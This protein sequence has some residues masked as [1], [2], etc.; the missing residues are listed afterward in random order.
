MHAHRRWKGFVY[1]LLLL[2]FFLL[3]FTLQG[4]SKHDMEWMQQCLLEPRTSWLPLPASGGRQGRH[5]EDRPRNL[6]VTVP[7]STH[8]SLPRTQCHRLTVCFAS[9][10]SFSLTAAWEGTEKPHPHLPDEVTEGYQDLFLPPGGYSG[11]A[12]KSERP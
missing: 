12:F 7:A 2:F 3:F 8:A 9:P 6:P 11:K 1:L 4:S 10:V 5:N